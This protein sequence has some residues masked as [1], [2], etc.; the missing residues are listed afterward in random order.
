MRYLFD[1]GESDF[2]LIGFSFR[3][4]LD[5]FEGGGLGWIGVV[6][7][8][9]CFIEDEKSVIGEEAESVGVLLAQTIVNEFIVDCLVDDLLS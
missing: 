1:D 7:D 6:D 4:F 5:C 2:D 3:D 8:S 9:L